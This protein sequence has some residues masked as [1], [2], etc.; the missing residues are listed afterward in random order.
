MEGKNHLGTMM[1]D[2]LVISSGSHYE[3]NGEREKDNEEGLSLV[4]ELFVELDMGEGVRRN[5][6]D[7]SDGEGKGSNSN[8]GKRKRVA[9]V[10]G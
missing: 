8:R 2:K 7:E 3:L 6:E 10:E 4:V 5:E 1:D 9:F